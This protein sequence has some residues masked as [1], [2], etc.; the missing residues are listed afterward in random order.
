MFAFIREKTSYLI[1]VLVVLLA[2]HV[3]PAQGTTLVTSQSGL[4]VNGTVDWTVSGPTFTLVAGPAYTPIP[5]LTETSVMVTG[6][7]LGGEFQRR[8]QGNGWNGSFN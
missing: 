8:N 2:V 7:A 5:G 4:T 3:A 1:A 6:A